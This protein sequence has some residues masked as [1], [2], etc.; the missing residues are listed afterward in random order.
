MGH[1]QAFGG[2]GL[3]GW[4]CID[5]E[6]RGTFYGHRLGPL[7]TDRPQWTSVLTQGVSSIYGAKL[8]TKSTGENNLMKKQLLFWPLIL[9]VAFTINPLQA[10]TS[11][12]PNIC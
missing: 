7:W 4:E 5:Y 12:K 6:L 9:G 3:Q 10:N 2:V 11:A 1:G 8:L